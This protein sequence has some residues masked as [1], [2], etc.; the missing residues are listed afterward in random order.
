ML[1]LLLPLVVHAG[2]RKSRGPFDHDHPRWINPYGAEKPFRFLDNLFP[3]APEDDVGE[4]AVGG[5]TGYLGGTA[6][7]ALIVPPYAVADPFP[8]GSRLYGE[9]R[10]PGEEPQIVGR[11]PSYGSGDYFPPHEVAKSGGIVAPA[12]VMPADQYPLMAP[13]DDFHPM[14]ALGPEDA[15]PKKYARYLDQVEDLARGCTQQNGYVSSDCTVACADGEDVQAVFGNTLRDVKLEAI[16]AEKDLA[17]VSWD[18]AL[19]PDPE[20][21]EHSG[22]IERR[23]LSKG[24][25]VCAPTPA[26][27]GAASA[28]LLQ[29]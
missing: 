27:A 12:S 15:L 8:Q 26:V 22:T 25:K 29:H 7:D 10:V 5:G 3:V 17:K 23:R 4:G 11:D 18:T 24:G 21:G 28:A 20:T 2:L 14:P 13:A 9:L 1:L 16:D 19:D 6:D